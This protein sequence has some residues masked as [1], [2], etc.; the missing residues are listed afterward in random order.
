MAAYSVRCQR[1]TKEKK[2]KEGMPDVQATP[3]G[4]VNM[5]SVLGF[6][7]SA[8]LLGLA[9]GRNDGFGL[10]AVLALS[11]LST[12][13]GIGNRWKLQLKK[14]L[15]TRK[16]PPSD[17]VINYPNGAFLIIKCTEEVAREF[18]WH[19]EE[20]IYTVSPRMY[21]IISLF[22]T[23]ILM[24][25]VI[26]LGNATIDLQLGFAASYII[27]NAAYWV[28][29]AL[30]ARWNWDLSHYSIKTIDYD[31]GEEN[32]Q[33]TAALWKAIAIT[34]SVHWVKIGSIAPISKGWDEW[35]RE[36]EEMVKNGKA[37]WH[38]HNSQEDILIPEWDYNEALTRCLEK[39][40]DADQV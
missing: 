12:F 25:G 4:P 6:I 20:C 1:I 13:I 15:S 36:A 21:R 40:T 3:L 9:I 27:L 14:R 11:S 30:P 32:T 24:F 2:S 35:I 33:F 23:L 39:V 26:C 28:V 37:G 29:A 8:A 5:L 19:P 34:Q 18:Y 10:V 38:Q 17:V 31:G 16:V 7:L 22:G